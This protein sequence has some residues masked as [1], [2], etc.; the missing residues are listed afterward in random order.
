MPYPGRNNIYQA[1][2]RRMVTQE[3]QRQEE[4][5]AAEHGS[6]REETLLSYLVEQAD[7]LGHTPWPREIPGGTLL[8]ERF[9]TWEVARERAGLPPQKTPDKLTRFSRYREETLR[10]QEIYRRHK[11][12]KKARV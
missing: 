4:M 7:R 8:L 1:T 12:E 11:A 6:D 3:F 10:Q 9:G 2:I 5:F